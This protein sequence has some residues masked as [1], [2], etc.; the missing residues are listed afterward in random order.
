MAYEIQSFLITLHTFH[1]LIQGLDIQY[2]RCL[3]K[4]D[5][6]ITERTS[7]LLKIQV[8]GAGIIQLQSYKHA[9]K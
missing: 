1:P 3:S 2:N 9:I 8:F 6:K 5:G 7:Y 4:T